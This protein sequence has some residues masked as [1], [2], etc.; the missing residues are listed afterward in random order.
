MP[1]LSAS[2][3]QH[4]LEAELDEAAHRY[5][6]RLA[7]GIMDNGICIGGDEQNSY[8]LYDYAENITPGPYAERMQ[9]VPDAALLLFRLKYSQYDSKREPTRILW[10]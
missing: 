9:T 2:T 8:R 3:F 7:E 1:A 6:Q 4:C 10:T 5:T